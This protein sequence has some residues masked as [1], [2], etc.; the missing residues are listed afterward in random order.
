MAVVDGHRQAIGVAATLKWPNDVVVERSR[1]GG[2]VSRRK[3]AGILAEG[4]TSAASCSTSIVGIGVNL[5]RTRTIRRLAGRAI[6]IEE[7]AGRGS[8]ARPSRAEVLAALAGLAQRVRQ[9]A[10][11]RSSTRGVRA[12][13]RATVRRCA[14]N[15]GRRD[16]V[17]SGETAG[18]RR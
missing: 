2:E 12:R 7:L 8:I 11:A 15:H 6:A 17:T 14:W 5:R 16:R 13:P 4:S 10:R 3:L 9:P 18:T 1:D